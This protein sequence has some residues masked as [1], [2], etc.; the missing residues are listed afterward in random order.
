MVLSCKAFCCCGFFFAMSV[1]GVS[2]SCMV[3]LRFT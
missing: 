3:D 1:D 2:G